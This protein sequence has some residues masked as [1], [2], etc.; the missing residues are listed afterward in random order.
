MLQIRDRYNKV[1]CIIRIILDNGGKQENNLFFSF[2]V[3]FLLDG[4]S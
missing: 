3:K 4:Q 2:T 1:I